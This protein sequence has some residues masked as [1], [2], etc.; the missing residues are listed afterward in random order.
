MACNYDKPEFGFVILSN[1]EIVRGTNTYSYDEDQIAQWYAT[2]IIMKQAGAFNDKPQ[3]EFEDQLPVGSS[4]GSEATQEL[5]PE[6][7]PE[8]PATQ[9]KKKSKKKGNKKGEN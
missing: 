5:K 4:A 1:G 3:N 9:T 6:P 2:W 7:A 8:Q